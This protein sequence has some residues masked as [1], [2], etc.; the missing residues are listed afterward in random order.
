MM[1]DYWMNFDNWVFFD[2][3]SKYTK[4]IISAKKN[5]FVTNNVLGHDGITILKILI[6]DQ[7]TVKSQK[8]N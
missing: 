6:N 5:D 8:K 4:N 2:L 3:E 1:T 7:G